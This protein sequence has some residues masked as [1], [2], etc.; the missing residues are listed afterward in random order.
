MGA[1]ETHTF[2]VKY[3]FCH[4]LRTRDVYKLL[5]R[6]NDSLFLLSKQFIFKTALK[7]QSFFTH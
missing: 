2:S 4:P 3:N 6:N 7:T 5:W 1:P